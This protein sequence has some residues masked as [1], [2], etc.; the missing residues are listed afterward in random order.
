M[1]ARLTTSRPNT[2]LTA[3]RSRAKAARNPPSPA[4]R[5]TLTGGFRLSWPSWPRLPGDSWPC[6]PLLCAVVRPVTTSGNPQDSRIWPGS[7]LPSS[8]STSRGPTNIAPCQYA[9]DL[10]GTYLVGARAAGSTAQNAEPGLAGAMIPVTTR[11]S[12]GASRSREPTV[13]PNRRAVAVVTATW[14][15]WPRL[16]VGSEPVMC[17]A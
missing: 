17:L 11:V 15:S 16:T 2:P 1:A 14:N 3:S 12:D 6:S 4:E 8:A 7:T 13:T 9:G 5:V 10:S